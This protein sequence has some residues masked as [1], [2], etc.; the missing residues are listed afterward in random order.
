M[1]LNLD[2]VQIPFGKMFSYCTMR[3]FRDKGNSVVKIFLSTICLLN[4]NAIDVYIVHGTRQ[5][6][7]FFI[8]LAGLGNFATFSN[9]TG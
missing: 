6:I 8:I 7:V 9:P 5:Q 3:L 2:L 1:S 4:Y